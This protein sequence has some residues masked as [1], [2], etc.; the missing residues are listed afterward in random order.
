MN[1]FI[2][3]YHTYK[4]ARISRNWYNN[5][6]KSLLIFTY[7]WIDITLNFIIELLLNN[8]YN[9][10]L[11]II[12]QL[13]KRKNYI[14]YNIDKNSII[15][16]TTSYLLLNNVWKLNNLLLLF[17][18]NVVIRNRLM[19]PQSSRLDAEE[20]ADAQPHWYRIM[21]WRSTSQ[22]PSQYGITSD[23]WRSKL[24]STPIINILETYLL[25]FMFS[26]DLFYHHQVITTVER[27]Y[28]VSDVW[29][30][31]LACRITKDLA[32]VKMVSQMTWCKEIKQVCDA[33][34]GS[35][36]TVGKKDKK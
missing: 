21:F 28:L 7:S 22:W 4:W 33:E 29:T 5:I 8:G 15:T 34:D 10:V 13:T 11:M 25:W 18:C 27:N 24:G 36:R 31:Y 30:S 1:C 14:L 6:L 3:N 2:Q 12:D 20:P 32:E 16:K 35:V 9:I 19:E 17:I 26:F 23:A